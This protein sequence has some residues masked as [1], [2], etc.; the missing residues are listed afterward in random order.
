MKLKPTREADFPVRDDPIKTRLQTDCLAI[1]Q[2]AYISL[3]PRTTAHNCNLAVLGATEEQ[4]RALVKANLG[5]GSC[6]YV[7]LTDSEESY[8]E[9]SAIL[10]HHGYNV[11]A[12]DLTAAVRPDREPPSDLLVRSEASAI[13][14]LFDPV[15][16]ESCALA[17]AL[18][19]KTL[20][21][22]YITRIKTTSSGRPPHI[23]FFLAGIDR[24]PAMPG[25]PRSLV[26]ARTNGMG[27]CFS[28]AGYESLAAT[29]PGVT[30]DLLDSCDF[31]LLY[32]ANKTKKES[33]IISRL[34]TLLH[35]PAPP[36]HCELHVTG[37]AP[38]R[39]IP[40]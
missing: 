30:R 35:L 31:H 14:F 22:V 36:K 6:N 15:S 27:I 11:S 37:L 29:Y 16:E 23:Q 33:P 34:K 21:A 10:V 19:E 25:L 26:T 8:N 17:G 5:Q 28:G 3:D 20:R 39:V 40:L 24:L 32:G 7:V 13:F 4:F 2:N 12:Y 1:A 38:R 18:I 9:I